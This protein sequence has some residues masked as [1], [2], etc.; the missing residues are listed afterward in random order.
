METRVTKDLIG[1]GALAI[2]VNVSLMIIKIIVGMAGNSY[3]LVA[4]GIESASDIFTSLI[5]WSGFHLSLKPPDRNHPFGHGKIESLAGIFSGLS[6]LAA[7]AFIAFSSVREIYTPHHAPEWFTLPVL[8]LVVLVKEVLSRKMLATGQD[9]GSQAI[10]GDAWH[11]RSD[12]ITSGAAAIGIA[13]A[14][15]GGKG[16][17][18]ADDCAALVACVIIV[19]NGVAII[20]TALHDILDGHVDYAIAE[21]VR[22]LAESVE[23]VSNVEKIRIRKSGISLYAE[24]HVRVDANMTVFR[25]H[26][27]SH[28][29]KDKIMAHDSRFRDVLIHLEPDSHIAQI[30]SS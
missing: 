28:A 23:G 2:G 21:S 10:Q 15:I 14:L 17:E 26:A 24:L 5:T 22:T 13:I 29:V 18:M 30:G 7:A 1:L 9:I 20:R 8:L 16:Y 4:D 3:A 27:I 19:I 11:H 12:A 6:L 25:G